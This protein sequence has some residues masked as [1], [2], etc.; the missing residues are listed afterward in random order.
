MLGKG[1]AIL[2]H[3]LNPGL[4]VLSGRGAKAERILMS[5]VQEGLN[6]YC[7]PRLVEHTEIVV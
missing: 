5:P 3:I 7:I 4:I 2:I 6:Q 1:I